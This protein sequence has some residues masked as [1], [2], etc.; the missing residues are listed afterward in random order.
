MHSCND[1]KRYGKRNYGGNGVCDPL[2]A[3]LALGR[4][5]TSALHLNTNYVSRVASPSSVGTSPKHNVGYEPMNID[6]NAANRFPVSSALIANMR[7][8]VCTF[9]RTAGG[10]CSPDPSL[11]HE[12]V[13]GEIPTYLEHV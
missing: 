11:K 6:A 4:V 9:S 10:R 5:L 12:H 8:A 2:C 7:M 1:I 3:M 13:I